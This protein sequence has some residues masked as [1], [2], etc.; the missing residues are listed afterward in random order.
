MSSEI[1][2]P[3]AELVRLAALQPSPATDL[4]VAA[5]ES[6]G[7]PLRATA[8]VKASDLL[9]TYRVRRQRWWDEGLPECVGL[10]EF[11]DA[12]E[13]LGGVDVVIADYPGGDRSFV[14]LVTA[15]LTEMAGCIAIARRESTAPSQT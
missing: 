12:L 7:E 8:S 9:E 2:V 1:R 3:A 5:A 4:L 13:R 6:R 10:P 11:V 14:V 15:D